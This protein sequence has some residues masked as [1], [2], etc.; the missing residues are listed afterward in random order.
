M[1]SVRAPGSVAE[2]EQK[3]KLKESHGDA[4][5]TLT[6][7][8][9]KNKAAWNIVWCHEHC[10]K[11][12][13]GAIALRLREAATKFGVSLIC[14][15]KSHNYVDWLTTRCSLPHL[16]IVNWREAKPSLQGIME[17]EIS[18]PPSAIVVLA[19]T[20]TVSR[21]A[22][23]WA[24][25]Y[26]EVSISVVQENALNSLDDLIARQSLL[27]S[28]SGQSEKTHQNQPPVVLK[29]AK[30]SSPQALEN[31]SPLMPGMILSTS[32]V[33]AANRAGPFAQSKN[34]TPPTTLS[35]E[36]TTTPPPSRLLTF[37]MEAVQN[38]HVAAKIQSD[39]LQSM[40]ETYED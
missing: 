2:L 5:Q 17:H 33:P 30:P 36:E 29:T 18:T 31:S 25:T 21:R 20:Y 4:K 9:K 24:E 39:L 19:D 14:F 38:Q 7:T 6:R 28:Q 32:I 1:T 8:P 34:S 13:M 27:A 10:Y 15:K 3:K 11:A 37:L 23:S 40:P 16:L 12:D 22:L 26:K 35:L